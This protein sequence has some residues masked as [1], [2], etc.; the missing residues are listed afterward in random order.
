[1]DPEEMARLTAESIREIQEHKARLIQGVRINEL[2]SLTEEKLTEKHDELVEAAANT[3]AH[4]VAQKMRLLEQARV[5]ANELFRR[6]SIRQ[7]ER[8]ETLT[9]SLNHLT[10]WIVA[11]TV[12]VS[13]A[14]IIGV[15]LTALTLILGG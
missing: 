3:A 1:M 2:Y 11:L 7:E 13:I 4:D 12:L 5:Y 10:K 14:T 6:E 15:I 9:R 8:M